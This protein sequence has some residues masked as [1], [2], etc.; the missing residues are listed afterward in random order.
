MKK[1]NEVIRS[2]VKSIPELQLRDLYDRLHQ[3]FYGDMAEALKIFQESPEIDRWLLTSKNVVEFFEMIDT[4][5]HYVE[6]EYK[7]KING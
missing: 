7:K 1:N 3:N 2:Y 6:V 5:K 4:L